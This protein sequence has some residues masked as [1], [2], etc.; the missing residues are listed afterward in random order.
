ML[1]VQ[2]QLGPQVKPATP[3]PFA[4]SVET[5]KLLRVETESPHPAVWPVLVAFVATPAALSVN[6]TSEELTPQPVLP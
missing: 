4:F 3:L 6:V 1:K 2:P 5:V